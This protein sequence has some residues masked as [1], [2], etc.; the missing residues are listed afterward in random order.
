[1][2]G[3]SSLKMIVLLLHVSLIRMS[4]ICYVM[5]NNGD[6][7]AGEIDMTTLAGLVFN[8]ICICKRMPGI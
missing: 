4:L 2:P 7:Y 1:M 6:V 3:I 8:R 5:D